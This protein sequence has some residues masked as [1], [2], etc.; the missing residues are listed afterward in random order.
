MADTEIVCVDCSVPF[1]FTEGER[2]FYEGKGLTIPR[3]CK[4]CRDKKK[5]RQAQGGT[6]EQRAPQHNTDVGA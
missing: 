3:R 6:R 2:A 5:A 1:V 4:S